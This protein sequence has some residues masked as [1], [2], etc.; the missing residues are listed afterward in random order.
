MLVCI[1]GL[2]VWVA[3]ASRVP[4]MH[5]P[6][7]LALVQAAVPP[8]RSHAV[9]EVEVLTAAHAPVWKPEASW[10]DR[11]DATTTQPTVVPAAT[12]DPRVKA[13]PA[14]AVPTSNAKPRK[15]RRLTPVAVSTSGA[16]AACDR[17]NPYGEALCTQGGYPYR[18]WS[19]RH[20]RR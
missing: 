2:V 12:P 7:G 6:P 9:E 18:T 19:E 17:Y 10:V 4:R 8:P 11:Q 1:V 20:G 16:R 15:D 14:R 3:T 13:R 5:A